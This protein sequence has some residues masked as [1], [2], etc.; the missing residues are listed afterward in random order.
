MNTRFADATRTHVKVRANLFGCLAALG[1]VACSP[2]DD[3]PNHEGSGGAS[4]AQGGKLASNGGALGNGGTIQNAFGGAP[5]NGGNVQNGAGGARGGTGPVFPGFGGLPGQGG[6]ANRGGNSSVAGQFGF[7]GKL[8]GGG[9][10]GFGGGSTTGGATASGGSTGSGGSGVTGAPKIP[11]INGTC[12]EFKTATATI[13]GLSGISLQVGPKKDGTGSLLFYWHGT[14][15]SA[16][17]VNRLVPARVR[18]EILDAGG[19]IVSFGG[20]TRTGGDCSGTSTFSKDDFKIA[21]LIA[22]CAV[23]NHGINPARIYTTGC[24]AG[25]LQA[26]C[27]GAMRSSYV[28]AVVP[29]SGG[30]VTRQPIQDASTTPAVMT[31]HG[32]PSDVVGVRFSQTSATYDAHMKSAGSYV[33]NCDHGGGHCQAPAELYTAGWE[34]MKAHPFGLE[35]EPYA[36]GLPSSFPSYC[37]PY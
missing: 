29:N 21:D 16:A 6:A 5:S 9:Q 2:A 34:F 22:A 12:P 32:G 26:G 17:E 24:S 23:Q 15:S 3:Y 30:E 8:G 25:G 1:L 7:G 14:G 20:S 35:P 11:P 33:V 19:I 36:S 28:A 31:M 27:M 10:F 18:Q 37:K 4:I 13:G